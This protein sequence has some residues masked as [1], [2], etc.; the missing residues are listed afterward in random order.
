MRLLPADIP[1]FTP[2]SD[3][4]PTNTETD[5]WGW[6]KRET[7]SGLYVDLEKGLD[8]IAEAIHHAGGIDG[9]IGLCSAGSESNFFAQK[10]TALEHH[11]FSLTIFCTC[12]ICTWSSLLVVFVAL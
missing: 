11:T 9:V 1:G 5:A 4:D 6:F 10:H 2:P 8:I 3:S 7:G 12:Y